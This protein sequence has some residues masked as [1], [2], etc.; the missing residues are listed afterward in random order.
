MKAVEIIVTGKKAGV[1]TV[2]PYEHEIGLQFAR[3]RGALRD[4]LV[5][6][7]V[8]AYE[9]TVSNEGPFRA[10]RFALRNNG[11]V[12]TE[13]RP[14]DTGLSHERV[15]IPSWVPSYSPRSFR[16][17]SVPGAWRLLPGKGFLIHEGPAASDTG[18]SIGCIEILDGKWGHFLWQI[19]VSGDAKCAVLAAS[20]KVTV[21]IEAA[22]YPV[23]TLL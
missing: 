8:P 20:R 14:C 15:C 18:G 10:I 23:A 11:S 2:T 6:Y 5:K 19:E 1:A 16:G 21:K 17:N 12:P 22:T 13:R 9:V 3:V 4:S 7:S